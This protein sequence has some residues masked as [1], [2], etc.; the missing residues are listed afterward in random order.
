MASRWAFSA[1]AE[2]SLPL[3]PTVILVLHLLSEHCYMP[4]SMAKGSNYLPTFSLPPKH[5][6]RR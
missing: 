1:Q 6:G 4:L 5:A 3:A 2:L